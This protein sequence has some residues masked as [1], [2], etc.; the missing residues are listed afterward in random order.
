VVSSFYDG[1]VAS[2]RCGNVWMTQYHPD[3]T[4]CGIRMLN[5]FLNS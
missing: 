4:E 5:D 2:V 1:I 3:R